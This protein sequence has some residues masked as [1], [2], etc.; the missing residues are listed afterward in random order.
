MDEKRA[1]NMQLDT[2]RFDAIYFLLDFLVTPLTNI[3]SHVRTNW[4]ACVPI[5]WRGYNIS[6]LNETMRCLDLE[7]ASGTFWNL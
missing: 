5:G 6:T 4:V 7:T 2:L 1:P 3:D